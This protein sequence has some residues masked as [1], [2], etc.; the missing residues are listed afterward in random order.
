MRKQ[1][2]TF[3][4]RIA[5]V[6]IVFTIVYFI[7]A[8][9]I[10]RIIEESLNTDLTHIMYFYSY[11]YLLEGI[12]FC[13]CVST[14]T[15]AMLS[16]YQKI[17]IIDSSASIGSIIGAITLLSVASSYNNDNLQNIQLTVFN[18]S[19]SLAE[20]VTYTEPPQCVGVYDEY[21][22]YISEISRGFV[23]GQA[24]NDEFLLLYDRANFLKAINS[25]QNEHEIIVKHGRQINI[26]MQSI[27]LIRKYCSTLKILDDRK[28]TLVEIAQTPRNRITVGLILYMFLVT[29]IISSL[30]K[31]YIASR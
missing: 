20:E 7:S 16:F 23:I 17:E 26:I 27:S 10:S 30:R 12:L 1:L 29:K 14:L 15:T 22:K 19:R 11:K 28:S 21:C 13:T 24:C 18:M 8:S 31:S 4:E 5:S 2:I 3:I 25:L 6:I 9:S